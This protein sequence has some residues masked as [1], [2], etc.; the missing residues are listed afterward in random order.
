MQESQIKLWK[1]IVTICLICK[2]Y[3]GECFQNKKF[4]VIKSKSKFSAY[5]LQKFIRQF[6][7]ICQG[8]WI[9]GFI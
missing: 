1:Y 6:W 9:L 7:E 5:E 2:Q 3:F 8:S 4:I